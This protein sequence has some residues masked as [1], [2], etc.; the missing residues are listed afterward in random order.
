LLEHENNAEKERRM[1]EQKKRR[2]VRPQFTLGTLL[3]LITVCALFLAYV[4]PIRWANLQR[5]QAY[6][7]AIAKGI[8]F[9]W[10]AQPASSLKPDLTTLQK[11][12]GSI[13]A[14]PH[15]PSFSQVQIHDSNGLITNEDLKQLELLP[16]IESLEFIL[17]GNVTDEGLRVLSKLPK[18]KQIELVNLSR[19]TGDFLSNF[20]E[21]SA[22]EKIGLVYLESLD[23]R[24][25]K[26]LKK[27]KNLKSLEFQFLPL[28]TDESLRDVEL[29]SSVTNLQVNHVKLGDE[30][31]A[32]WLTQVKLQRLVIHVPITRAFAPALAQQTNLET[33]SINNTPLIDEDFVFLKEC[34]QLKLLMLN[35]M[36]I[37]G[38]VLDYVAKPDQVSVLEFSNSLFSDEHLTKLSRFPKLANLNLAWTPL[39]GEGFKAESTWPKFDYLQLAGTRFS[40]QGKEAFS[41]VRGMHN[42]TLPS[43][44]SPSDH[45]RFADSDKPAIPMFNMYFMGLSGFFLNPAG[46]GNP[47]G[48]YSPIMQLEKIDNCP[49][50]VMK[51]VADLHALGIAEDRELGRRERAGQ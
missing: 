29:P 10:P 28:L 32:R 42:V 50:D 47:G 7:V 45:V 35:S 18:L 27:F 26:S 36:P 2:F 33:L 51:P 25:L 4:A 41:K 30:T 23:A 22:L 3:I 48:G 38:E 19:V 34:P 46:G 37:R 9:Q 20:Y 49:A 21:D 14:D 1:T 17:S 39:T 11:F 44:W 15:L 24:N 43:N 13:T 12:W 8:K 31:L 40:P 16:E 5:K 6:D